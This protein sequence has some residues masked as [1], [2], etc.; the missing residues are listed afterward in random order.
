MAAEADTCTFTLIL[1]A[2]REAV[3]IYSLSM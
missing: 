1:P 2:L 3:W